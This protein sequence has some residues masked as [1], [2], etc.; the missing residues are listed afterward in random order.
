MASIKPTTNTIMNSND[1]QDEI[2]TDDIES[3]QRSSSI[4]KNHTKAIISNSQ[5][6]KKW[7]SASTRIQEKKIE[8]FW[9]ICRNL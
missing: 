9:K 3:Q 2:R 1:K 5:S 4:F 6:I 7:D 8:K